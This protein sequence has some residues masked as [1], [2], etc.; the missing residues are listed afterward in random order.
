ML[1]GEVKG[2]AA[3]TAFAAKLATCVANARATGISVSNESTL[4]NCRCPLG[5][6][7]DSSWSHPPSPVAAREGWTEVPIEGLRSFI[8]GYSKQSDWHPQSP[9]YQLGRAYR[10]VFP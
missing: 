3:F 4:L 5:C 9:Y 10:E 6:H 8:A 2:D 1:P 7:P